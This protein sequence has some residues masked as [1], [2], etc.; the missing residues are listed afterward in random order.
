MTDIKKEVLLATTAVRRS[1]GLPLTGRLTIEDGMLHCNGT[2]EREALDGDAE[3]LAVIEQLTETPIQSHWRPARI[4]IIGQ[5]GNDG[6]HYNVPTS[7][8]PLEKLRRAAALLNQ[9]SGIPLDRAYALIQEAIGAQPTKTEPPAGGL[10]PCPF[11]GGT[12]KLRRGGDRHFVRCEY[13][14]CE[15]IMPGAFSPRVAITAW[16]RRAAGSDASAPP[17]S[18]P[19]TRLLKEGEDPKKNRCPS[20]PCRNANGCP[21]GSEWEDCSKA[22]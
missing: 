5:N 1:Y 15:A 21:R 4:D 11:C 2:I 16:N 8:F 19:P 7:P 14:D 17:P 12:A 20:E 6:E 9:W 22:S 10:L 13:D 3:A 18:P